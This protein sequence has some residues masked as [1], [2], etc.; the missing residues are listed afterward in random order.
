VPAEQMPVD[1]EEIV[2]QVAAKSKFTIKDTSKMV[3]ALLDVLSANLLAGKT[4]HLSDF[5]TL[6]APPQKSVKPK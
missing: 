6:T 3:D 1:L 5:G 2:R 4:I